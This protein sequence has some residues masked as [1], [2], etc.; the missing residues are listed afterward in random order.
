[1]QGAQIHCRDR[2]GAL[3]V[4][5]HIAYTTASG[6]VYLAGLAV[7]YWKDQMEIA[8]LYHRAVF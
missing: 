3:L 5:P 1:M 6:A 8:M 7:A 4:C 2:P